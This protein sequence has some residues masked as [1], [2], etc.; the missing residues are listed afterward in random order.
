[1]SL[2]NI[3]IHDTAIVASN[4][5]GRDTRIWAFV[6]ILKGAVIG[7]NCNICDHCFIEDEVVIGNNVTLKCGI[8]VWN[9]VTIEDDV[10]L[11]PNV[12]FTNNIR[13]RI[14]QYKPLSL[15]LISKGAS[16]GANSTILSGITIGKYAMTGIASVVTRSIPDY[17]LVYGNPAKF[18]GWIDEE[19]QNLIHEKEGLWRSNSNKYFEEVNGILKPKI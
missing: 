16:I 14:K 5:I 7:E 15:T 10:F 6:N 2:K 18:K 1:M 19:G 9:G 12:V 3:S 17:A 8:Y 11:G 4:T 13:P